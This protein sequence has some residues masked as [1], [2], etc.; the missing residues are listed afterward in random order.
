MAVDKNEQ[1]HATLSML[2]KGAADPDLKAIFGG[3]IEQFCEPVSKP[4]PAP[5]PKHR[6]EPAHAEA[7]GPRPGPGPQ[8]PAAAKALPAKVSKDAE[9]PKDSKA[10][11]AQNLMKSLSQRWK[12]LWSWRSILPPTV[13][14][15]RV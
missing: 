14:S 5:E 11:D 9:E 2:Q 6:A 4:E 10:A 15:M 8:R 13:V 7:A 12:N 1:L 3:L